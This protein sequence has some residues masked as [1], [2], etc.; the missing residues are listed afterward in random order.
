MKRGF[1]LYKYLDDSLDFNRFQMTF[2]GNSPIEF[3]HIKHI[4][5]VPSKE[6]ASIL[7]DH[8]IYITA[9]R[10]DP[11]SNSLIEALHCGLPAV[12]RN[13]GGHPEIIGNAGE[14]FE[15][16]PSVIAAIEKVANNYHDYQKQISLLSIEDIGHKYY[17]FCSKIY[18]DFQKGIY[19]PK[20]IPL[21][22]EFKFR[23]S[24]SYQTILQKLHEI[25]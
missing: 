8:D 12:A 23:V 20:T 17:L 4:K 13:D 11:C 16:E 14:L 24:F 9:S 21:L 22:D 10:N 3:N 2:V 15:N 5:P 19:S 1:D 25:I 18:E 7:K 6:L